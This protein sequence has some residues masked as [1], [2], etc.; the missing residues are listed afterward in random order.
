MPGELSL[1]DVRKVAR[2]ARLAI[3][4]AELES[5][6]SRLSAVL[7]YFERLRELNLDGVEPLSHPL[8]ATNRLDDDTPG[9]TLPTSVLMDMA[10]DTMPPFLKVPKVL[11]EGA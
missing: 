6:R 9:P 8:D 4:D 1:D 3:P 7:G 10:P 2:L 5:Y 11:G